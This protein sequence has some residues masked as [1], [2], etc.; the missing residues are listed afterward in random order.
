MVFDFNHT[1]AAKWAWKCHISLKIVRM[2]CSV[3]PKKRAISLISQ[4]KTQIEVKENFIKKTLASPPS[5]LGLFL[6]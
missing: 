1:Q 2:A 4:G 6:C 5:S 3:I